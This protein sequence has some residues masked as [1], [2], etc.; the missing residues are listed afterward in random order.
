[1]KQ[2]DLHVHSTYSDGTFT[3]SMLIE[4]AVNKGL[5]AIALT[6]HDA[7]DGIDEGLLAAGKAGIEL[8]PGI[9]FSTFYNKKEIHIVGL[10]IDHKNPEFA[11]RLCDFR[12]GRENKNIKMC[13]KFKEIG[14]D[15]SY[16]EMKEMYPNAVITR[17]H[18]ADYLLK[19]GIV[20]DRNEAFDRYIGDGCV[21]Y[22]DREKITPKEAIELIHSVGGVAVLAH[23]VLYHLGNDAMQALMDY[24]CANGL[25]ALEAVYSTYSASDERD[26][27]RLAA[28]YGILISGGSDFHGQNKPKISLGTGLGR[29]FV[30]DEVLENLRALAK[31]S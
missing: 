12:E 21:C 23:P 18:F 22:V 15:V 1:M 20:R 24:L 10:F 16:E 8:I 19:K 5:S 4:E 26:M 17:A 7:T 9:E 11:R 31:Q 30:P 6:D 28:K 13:E 2:V 3:P 29:L 25:Q 14:I 27:R